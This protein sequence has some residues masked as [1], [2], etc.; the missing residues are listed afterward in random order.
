[1]MLTVTLQ[2][3]VPV[4]FREVGD[5]FRLMETA[6]DVT[7]RFFRQGQMMIE[8]PDVSGGY[9]ERFSGER[10]DAVELVSAGTQD[11]QFAIRL[12]NDVRF[13]APPTGAVTI[14]GQQGAFSQTTF[15]AGAASAEAL[16]A[17]ALRRYLLIQNRDAANAAYV[18][19]DGAAATVADGVEI[20]ALGSLEISGYVPTDAIN[21][22][23]AGAAVSLIVVEG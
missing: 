15:A 16:A 23:T 7:V 18:S 6:G 20:P 9:A 4:I 8:S 11:V 2:A 5:F 22:I 17:N 19:L 14:S 12:G 10:F 21:A 3:G 13:D 1:M